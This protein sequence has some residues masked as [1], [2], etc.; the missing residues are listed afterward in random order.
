MLSSDMVW[1]TTITTTGNVN[2]Q[3]MT[4]FKVN[5]EIG[6]FGWWG[7][8]LGNLIQTGEYANHSLTNMM[9]P[10]LINEQ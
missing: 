7:T 6:N 8:C 4:T 1:P 2:G 9:A 10:I 5:K 3:E